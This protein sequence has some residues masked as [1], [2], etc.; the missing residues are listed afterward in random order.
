MMRLIPILSIAIASLA[1]SACD[2]IGEIDEARVKA[3]NVESVALAEKGSVLMPSVLGGYRFA[4]D[5]AK[6]DGDDVV[7]KRC[8]ATREASALFKKSSEASQTVSSI[9]MLADPHA[10]KYGFERDRYGAEYVLY[11]N[12]ADLTS[13]FATQCD[14]FAADKSGAKFQLTPQMETLLSEIGP[15]GDWIGDHK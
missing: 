7:R 12:V 13:L 1:L 11:A 9:F 8:A 10:K 3:L 2:S 15:K 5:F 14:A 6:I 4:M